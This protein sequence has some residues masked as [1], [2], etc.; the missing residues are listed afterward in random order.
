MF[1]LKKYICFVF[2]PS[3]FKLD[4]YIQYFKI[5]NILNHIFN[6]YRHSIYRKFKIS[7][8]EL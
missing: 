3:Y 4:S 2:E 6:S 8:K 7:V 1:H 5:A